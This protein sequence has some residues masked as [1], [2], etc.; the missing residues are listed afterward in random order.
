MIA[1]M[2]KRNRKRQFCEN[3]VAVIGLFCIRKTKE[4]PI[5]T[6]LSSC[7]EV[8]VRGLFYGAKQAQPIDL[9]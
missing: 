2:I 6:L 8:P 9:S 4:V 5:P 7:S 1:K 3:P